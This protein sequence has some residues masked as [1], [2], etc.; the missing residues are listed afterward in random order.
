MTKNINKKLIIASSLAI[1]IY[2]NTNFPYIHVHKQVQETQ[3]NTKQI[4]KQSKKKSDTKNFYDNIKTFM[5]NLKVEEMAKAG[6][7]KLQADAIKAEEDRIAKEE[8]SKNWINIEVTYYTNSVE[9]CG[10]TKAVSANG[11]NLIDYTI[12]RGGNDKPYYIP[13]AC[14]RDI[15]F[16]TIIK[17]SGL[18]DCICVDR[19]GMIKWNKDIMKIDVFTINATQQELLSKGK[20]LTKG[21]IIS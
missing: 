16:G 3:L 18:G 5:N 20:W 9:N 13:I 15:P 2:V 8:A 6:M 19:G 17:I 11:T 14:P 7:N 12:S 4:T 21:Y 10:N 1:I